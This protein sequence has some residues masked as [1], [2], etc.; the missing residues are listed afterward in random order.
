M[1]D[2]IGFIET[3]GLTGA[4]E[5]ADA[6]VKS[7][8]V[9]LIGYELS[10]G[11]GMVTVKVDG[12]VGAVKS[13]I[14]AAKASSSKVSGVY[15]V[16]V[17]PRPAESSAMV[18]RTVETIP[19]ACGATTRESEAVHVSSITEEMSQAVGL[20]EDAIKS[21]HS[22]PEEGGVTHEPASLR[23]EDATLT[24]FGNVTHIQDAD[25]LQDLR[26]PTLPEYETGYGGDT[27]KQA[28]EVDMPPHSTPNRKKRG[29]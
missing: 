6:A 8:N 5:A 11:G 28:V 18:I 3:I 26:E 19:Q 15:S 22:T 14:D 4:I 9:R 17:I 24:T 29:R 12:D 21:D 23:E 25:V 16:N 10:R 27:E 2:A 7:A 13:A 1:A 20:P